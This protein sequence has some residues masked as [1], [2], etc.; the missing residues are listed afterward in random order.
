MPERVAR[1]R[2]YPVSVFRSEAMKSLLLAGAMIV[3]AGTAAFA[4]E[5]FWYPSG[6][7]RLAE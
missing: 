6:E 3:A 7:G 2:Y 1:K 4:V 5:G